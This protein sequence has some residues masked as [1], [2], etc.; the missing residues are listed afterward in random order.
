MIMRRHAI[1][2]RGVRDKEWTLYVV[3]L[4]EEILYGTM[5]MGILWFVGTK[6]STEK[7]TFPT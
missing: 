5:G 7:V 3:C 4:S 2:E 1:I 6:Q